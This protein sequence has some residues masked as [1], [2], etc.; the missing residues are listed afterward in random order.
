M[1]DSGENSLPPDVK[2]LLDE[3]YDDLENFRSSDPSGAPRKATAQRIQ[4]KLEQLRPILEEHVQPE[5]E[6]SLPDLA[7]DVAGKIGAKL[8]LEILESLIFF[9][10]FSRMGSRFHANFSR[11]FN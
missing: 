11:S 2:R 3:L 8:I 4:E 1:P 7:Y 5:T 10:L 6:A 9:F